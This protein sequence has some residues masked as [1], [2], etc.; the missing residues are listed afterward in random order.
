MLNRS[1]NV[2]I[3][4]YLNCP[5]ALL[6]WL[7]DGWGAWSTPSPLILPAE[8]CPI[9][10]TSCSMDNFQQLAFFFPS[11]LVAACQNCHS[12]C[13]CCC[14]IMAPNSIPAILIT[15]P[16]LLWGESYPDS[17]IPLSQR[18]RLWFWG[19]EWKG[20]WGSPG[21]SSALATSYLCLSAWEPRADSP[22]V[23]LGKDNWASHLALLENSSSPIASYWRLC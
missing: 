9:W 3:S 22:H 23:A 19:L 16:R 10:E 4:F 12:W 6:Q 13:S 14:Q 5:F 2:P 18:V 11:L 15:F 17:Q 7:R 20:R 8:N 1:I 21:P